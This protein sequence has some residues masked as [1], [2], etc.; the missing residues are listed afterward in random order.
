MADQRGNHY[1]KQF[2]YDELK[3]RITKTKKH[4][5]APYRTATIIRNSNQMQNL[6]EMNNV[7]MQEHQAQLQK[8]KL[9]RQ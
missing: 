8:E 7:D 9:N 6:L 2:K 4:I 1:N 3:H 5:N